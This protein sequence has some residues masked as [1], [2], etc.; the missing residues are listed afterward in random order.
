[1]SDNAST[2]LDLEYVEQKFGKLW[3][4]APLVEEV[5]ALRAE[6]ERLRDGIRGLTEPPTI[7]R[8]DDATLVADWFV[9]KAEALL[10]VPTRSAGARPS[11]SAPALDMERR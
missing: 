2:G 9:T 5:R 10:D 7:L 11:E 4:V 6:V 8:D 3:P 1:M